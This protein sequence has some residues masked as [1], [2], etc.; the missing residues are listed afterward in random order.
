MASVEQGSCEFVVR[1]FSTDDYGRTCQF[2][3]ETDESS[4]IYR[5][6]MKQ[7]REKQ[8]SA[9]YLL[10]AG[11]ILPVWFWLDLSQ[12]PDCKVVRH[13]AKRVEIPVERLAWALF[14]TD[15]EVHE[16]SDSVGDFAILNDQRGLVGFNDEK[17][18]ATLQRIWDTNDGGHRGR[19]M[20]RAQAMFWELRA[21]APEAAK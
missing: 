3:V 4:T 1:H 21:S 14:K 11:E 16:L 7:V 2:E 8:D 15:P 13:L 6:D 19:V 9:A 10:S 20:A 18:A 17:Q 12:Y 5:I